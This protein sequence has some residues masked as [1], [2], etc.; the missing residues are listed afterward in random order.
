MIDAGGEVD[1]RRFE[2]VIGRKVDGEEED[3]SRVWTISLYSSCEDP[4]NFKHVG[5]KT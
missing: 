5:E 4:S 2:R 3:T 1:L